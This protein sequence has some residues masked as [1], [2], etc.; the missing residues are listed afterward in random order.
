MQLKIKVV[1]INTN[2]V[3][4]L[5]NMQCDSTFAWNSKFS[6]S[7]FIIIQKIVDK[8]KRFLIRECLVT[9]YIKSLNVK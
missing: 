9:E 8:K 5:S 1:D 6:L 4:K 7:F 3:P 2:M